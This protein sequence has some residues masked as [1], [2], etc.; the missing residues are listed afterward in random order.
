M[1]ERRRSSSFA[2][3]VL[4]LLILN[5]TLP[6]VC[7]RPTATS[8]SLEKRWN[9]EG[10]DKC[11]K[12]DCNNCYA[13]CYTEC[14][15]NKPKPTATVTKTATATPTETVKRPGSN[16]PIWEIPSGPWITPERGFIG[17]ILILT[18]LFLLFGTFYSLRGALFFIGFLVFSLICFIALTNAEP[19]QGYANRIIV[20]M[21]ICFIFAFIG[22][23]IFIFLFKLA[24]FFIGGMGGFS[25]AMFILSWSENHI[26][27][28]DIARYFFI[29]SFVVLGIFLMAFI[30]WYVILF[31]VSITGAVCL[32]VGMDMF[33]NAGLWI[34]MWDLLDDN[35][36]HVIV[37]R[38]DWRVYSE[39]GAILALTL[40]G[41]AAS[42]FMFR[43]RRFPVSVVPTPA[44]PAK[45]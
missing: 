35:P 37:Y 36:N 28:N 32:I 40:I 7:A 10:K 6:L 22:G 23:M 45:A 2:Y 11:A 21:C 31:A 8:N 42:F 13:D 18:G 39:L 1:M 30:E 25:L 26:I 19:A 38:M 27:L 17:A 41:A 4:L 15:V 9:N 34:S 20:Y 12:C 3:F 5:L 16:E 43:G 24:L 44:A 29:V 33:I 14:C